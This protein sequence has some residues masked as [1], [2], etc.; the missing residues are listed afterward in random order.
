M[1]KVFVLAAV[2]LSLW[3]CTKKMAP[4][5]PAEPAVTAAPVVIPPAAPATAETG[6]INKGLLDRGKKTF[7]ASCG[8]CHA[9]KQPNAYTQQS[10]VGIMERMA[11][12]AQLDEA[13]KAAVLA[14]VQHYA[15]D[16]PQDKSNM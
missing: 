3:A 16:A 4:A 11:P 8:R 1:K 9:L 10:W 7:D 15:K 14:Y 2:A 6:R 5:K 13:E 12:K